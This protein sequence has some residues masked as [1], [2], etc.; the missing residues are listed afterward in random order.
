MFRTESEATKPLLAI[1]LFLPM[2]GATVAEEGL[3][4]VSSEAPDA[5]RKQFS[6]IGE[7]INAKLKLERRFKSMG[8][9]GAAGRFGDERRSLKEKEQ[10]LLQLIRKENPEMLVPKC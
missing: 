10:A 6:L 1:L 9:I 4:D 8:N 5:L 3:D 2:L 7:E